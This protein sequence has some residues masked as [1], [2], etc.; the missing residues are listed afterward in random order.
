MVRRGI[1]SRENGR[2]RLQAGRMDEKVKDDHA[3]GGGTENMGGTRDGVKEVTDILRSSL[4]PLDGNLP[5]QLPSG[6][7][8][9]H[10]K[11][12]REAIGEEVNSD[13]QR[14]QRG[15]D[16]AGM[17]RKIREL[18]NT[19]KRMQRE[20]GNPKI[21]NSAVGDSTT[22]PAGESGCARGGIGRGRTSGC[23][24]SPESTE[25]GSKESEVA[26]LNFTHSLP[27]MNRAEDSRHAFKKNISLVG[28]AAVI[29]F[30][31]ELSGICE[32]ITEENG[33]TFMEWSDVVQHNPFECVFHIYRQLGSNVEQFG[34]GRGH[35][36]RVLMRWYLVHKIV[37]LQEGVMAE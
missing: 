26:I 33:E 15:M 9:V 30:T 29:A 22:N 36:L 10:G 13:I 31:H 17:V 12:E 7:S 24:R 4:P 8:Y 25:S 21:G 27:G 35:A 6:S 37:E 2:S 18:E 14:I 32:W 23:G 19:V 11:I 34:C 5:S 16:V 3:E 28:N 20:R 1:H